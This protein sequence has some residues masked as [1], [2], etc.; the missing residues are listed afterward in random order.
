MG[1]IQLKSD[2]TKYKPTEFRG[3]DKITLGNTKLTNIE[4][5]KINSTDIDLTNI[6]SK[7]APNYN[8][9]YSSKSGK[10]S[11]NIPDYELSKNWMKQKEIFNYKSIFSIGSDTNKNKSTENSLSTN[12]R[13]DS[14][15]IDINPIRTRNNQ[16]VTF[17]NS[18]YDVKLITKQL[19]SITSNKKSIVDIK[20]VEYDINDYK[21]DIKLNDI[22]D[23]SVLQSS[24]INRKFDYANMKAINYNEQ[25]PKSILNRDRVVIATPKISSGN[26][27]DSKAFNDVRFKP[28]MADGLYKNYKVNLTTLSNVDLT[29][30][31]FYNS[32]YD[33]INKDVVISKKVD[34][35]R[36]PKL[37][38]YTNTPSNEVIPRDINSNQK[39]I[40]LTKL[41]SVYDDL[42]GKLNRGDLTNKRKFNSDYDIEVIK[43][44]NYFDD[45][46]QTNFNVNQSLSST[47]F[48]F[49][50]QSKFGFDKIPN[51]DGFK[52]RISIT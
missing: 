8:S 7:L 16:G 14:K 9:L 34:V 26:N 44:V 37:S 17:L 51:I 21:S 15:T 27:I 20:K 36:L 42:K 3:E 30:D 39:F 25:S 6:K 52:L 4:N 13:L 2:L 43:G 10:D 19:Q 50:F 32:G 29:D 11:Y 5:N 22:R 47:N 28:L 31:K 23:T 46:F 18:K 33:D 38:T 35:K 45:K 1:L 24:I 41:D 12:K 49:K 48:K 40:D